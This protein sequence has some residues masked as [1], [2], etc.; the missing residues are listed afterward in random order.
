MLTL[1][2]IVEEILPHSS[3]RPR[4]VALEEVSGR[5]IT[6]ERLA[7]DVDAV[8]SGLLQRGL[9]PGESVL[10]TIPPSIASIALILALVRAGATIV[11]ADPRMGAAVFSAPPS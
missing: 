7:R 11:A 3:R 2:A 8:T 9:R 4:A 6:Y 5:Q 1:P 10:F